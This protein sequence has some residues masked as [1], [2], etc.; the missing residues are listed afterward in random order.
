MTV[1]MKVIF[2]GDDFGLT[3]GINSGV[4]QSYKDGLLTSASIIAG[5]EAAGE[6][7]F[8]AKQ[9][10]NFDVGIHLVL[11]DERP[12]LTPKH[13][14]SIMLEGGFF[15]SRQRIFQAI[16]TQKIDYSQV[17]AEWCAQI[18]KC[19]AGGLII[20]HIDSHQFV[21]LFPDL[22]QLTL[23]L[24]KKYRI[25]FV[26]TTI[27]DMIRMEYGLKRLSQ[28]MLLKCWI[29]RYITCRLPQYLKT[30]PSIGFLQAG[31]KMRMA[32]LLSTIDKIRLQRSFTAV[33]VMLHPGIA[34]KRTAHKYRSWRYEWDHDLRLLQSFSLA[35]EL[36][37]RGVEIISF[38]D[39]M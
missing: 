28:W 25:P 36:H 34:D 19:L 31:G 7:I 21:H 8:W 5:G 29:W 15:P 20:S 4:I 9:N 24:A 16:V 11:S 3:A 38:R 35:K 32:T 1:M 22:F 14:S 2:H 33:E 23:R 26:R 10:E 30:I 17:E 13:L 37:R 12:V 18:E 6:A 27:F 39:L